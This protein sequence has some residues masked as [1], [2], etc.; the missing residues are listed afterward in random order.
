MKPFIKDM[1][2]DLEIKNNGIEIQVDDNNGSQIGDLY[3]TKTGMIWCDGR[4]RRSGG[5]KISW[6]EF[7][8]YMQSRE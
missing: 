7:Q 6:E 8:E 3:V 2:I 1:T 5:K 4:T